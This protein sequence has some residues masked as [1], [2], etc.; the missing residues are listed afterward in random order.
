L[1]CIDCLAAI[2]THN[3]QGSC[4]ASNRI[5]TPEVAERLLAE[6]YCDVVS[7]ARPLLADPHFLRKAERNAGDTINTCIG[8]NQACLDHGFK[9]IVA[10]CLVNPVACH[11]T[12]LHILPAARP[13][14][15]AVVG[16]GPAGLAAATTAAARGHAVTLFEADSEIG[17]QFNLAKRIP[18]KEEFFETLRY[19]HRQIEITG[20]EL[21]LN[22][23]VTAAE[24][25]AGGFDEIVLATGVTP[26]IPEIE[27]LDHPS[28]LDYFAAIR[29]MKPVGDSVAIIGAG[30]IGFDVAT[31]LTQSGES[32]SVNP[33]KFY[34]EWGI[35]TRYGAHSGLRPPN[36]EPPPRRVYLL[37]RKRAKIGEGLGV[38]TG[39]IHRATLKS[40][41]V[42]MIAG[43]TYR[44]ID[45][46]GLH[47]TVDGNDQ[48][49]PVKSIVI[50][51]G[52]LP[53]RSL[54]RQLQ[55]ANGS[56]HLIGGADEA[57]ELDAK[58]A[59]D[60]GVRLAARL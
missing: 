32:A 22:A 30:G 27:G 43:V 60:Q 23:R 17:G 53:E 5:N 2:E 3:R 33:E 50:C 13:R 44:R 48:L 52:Q 45:D 7:M 14:R 16:A 38:S 6:G 56:V 21:R 8:C 41:G 29:G 58:R 9:Q 39:W 54:A 4:T 31:L 57:I 36:V 25:D 15:I 49:L 37:Q 46:Q 34:A 35:D 59:I 18:G 1:L 24:L 42:E 26:R 20:V 10:S 12:E 28:V 51:T 19:F 40:R 11:E 55:R 47:L